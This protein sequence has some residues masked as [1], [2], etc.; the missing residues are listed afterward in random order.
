MPLRFEFES[1]FLLSYI[2]LYIF[3][4]QFPGTP[5][6]VKNK[7][8]ASSSPKVANIPSNSKK[9]TL[10]PDVKSSPKPGPSTSSGTPA[11]KAKKARKTK[12]FKKLFEGV[13]FSMSGFENPLRGQIRDKAV[14]MGAKYKA[15]WDRSCTHLMLVNH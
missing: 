14:E 8:I 3:H 12:P 4:M 15:D 9:R 11:K 6:A 13:V 10:S 7:S 2:V 1:V 5:T